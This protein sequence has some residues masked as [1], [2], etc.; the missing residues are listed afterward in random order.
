[1]TTDDFQNLFLARQF[2]FY[3]DVSFFLFLSRYSLFLYPIREATEVLLKQ[4]CPSFARR[5]CWMLLEAKEKGEILRF[6]LT[7]HMHREGINVR[8]VG[9]MLSSISEG[10]H[11]ND[12]LRSYLI[13]IVLART[14]KNEMRELMRNILK[15]RKYEDEV[16]IR[17]SLAKYLNF[18]LFV[19]EDA[20][21]CDQYWKEI[22]IPS[23]RTWFFVNSSEFNF[24]EKDW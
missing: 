19:H 4:T 7:Q 10:T 6:N 11:H 9:V 12:V 18:L 24:L 2:L 22:L 15:E 20:A 21:G 8:Y 3:S 5:L 14:I 16:T 1:M 17:T 13:T 23:M